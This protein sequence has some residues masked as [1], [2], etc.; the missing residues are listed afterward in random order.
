MTTTQPSRKAPSIEGRLA[1]SKKR[2]KVRIRRNQNALLVTGSR[3]DCFVV[4]GLQTIV[5]HMRGIM[6][7]TA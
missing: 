7:V 1:E 2:A 4:S 3:K 5:A 6:S